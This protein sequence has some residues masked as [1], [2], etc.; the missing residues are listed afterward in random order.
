MIIVKFYTNTPK[1]HALHVKAIYR[2]PIETGA[3]IRAVS[4]V[5]SNY[6]LS[7]IQIILSH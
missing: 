3:G 2:I 4:A 5:Q 6:V 7:K 1:N